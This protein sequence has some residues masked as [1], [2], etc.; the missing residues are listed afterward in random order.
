MLQCRFPENLREAALLSSLSKYLLSPQAA[1]A[2]LR[3]SLA[4]TA[5]RQ[6]YT[7]DLTGDKLPVYPRGVTAR[8]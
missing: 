8:P 2:A 7:P 3:I 4:Q 6:P 1:A 5:K